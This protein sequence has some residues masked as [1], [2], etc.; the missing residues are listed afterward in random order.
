MKGKNQKNIFKILILIIIFIFAFLII[1]NTY[2]KYM[3]AEDSFT[4]SNIAKWHIL[5]N[6]KDISE[7][8]LF[9]NYIP[10]EMDE[11][12]NI[13]QN[14]IAPTSNGHI[15]LS[16]ESTG[17]EL[18]YE[19]EIQLAKIISSDTNTPDT[20]TSLD[21]NTTVDSVLPDFRI[22]AYSINGGEKINLA[23]DEITIKGTVN[24]AIDADGNFTDDT[25]KNDFVLYVQ[26]YDEDDNIFDNHNDVI[27]SKLA[28][29][30][31][32]INLNVQVKQIDA[33]N[34]TP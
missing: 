34:V 5:L 25:V 15:N 13:N 19:Y 27:V 9:S 1:R 33:N 12:E 31:A 32:T 3:T 26:W 17:T 11:D 24:P 28:D 6:D 10:L 2:S 22:Y 29:P 21:T 14:I 30:T 23:S 18:P 20:N 7:N 4:K 16:L 8:K